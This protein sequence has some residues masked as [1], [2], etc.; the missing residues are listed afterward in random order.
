MKL[1]GIGSRIDH[2]EMGKGVV[3]N[4]STH[5]Y[6]VSFLDSGIE[7]IDLDDDFEVIEA[8]HG[9]VDTISFSEVEASL[10]QILRKWSDVTSLVPI[11]DKWKGGTLVL[12]PGDPNLSPKDIPIS[13]F[14]QA[15]RL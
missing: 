10:V 1:L 13:T 5:H 6:W 9:E 8:L 12:N 11:A 4:V 2:P 7:T 14:F 3:V 15:D